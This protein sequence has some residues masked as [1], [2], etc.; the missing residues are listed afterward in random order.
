MDRAYLNTLLNKTSIDHRDV[1][2]LNTNRYNDYHSSGDQERSR[3]LNSPTNTLFNRELNRNRNNGNFPLMNDRG[4][5]AAYEFENN[6]VN[7]FLKRLSTF[8]TTLFSS[9][10]TIVQVDQNIFLRGT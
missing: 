2:P 4:G 7:I 8:H 9:L 10:M 5:N 6:Q 3:Y 1:R